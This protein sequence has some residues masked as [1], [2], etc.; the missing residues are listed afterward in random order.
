VI[1]VED[2][3]EYLA[4]LDRA[5]IDPDIVPFAAFIADRVR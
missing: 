4:A 1:R 2:R 5:S 3:T